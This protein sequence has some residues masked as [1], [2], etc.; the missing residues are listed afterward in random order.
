MYHFYSIII[1]LE[2]VIER[3]W[4]SLWKLSRTQKR[5]KVQKMIK[6]KEVWDLSLL[7]SVSVT[8]LL[9]FCS[10]INI[11]TLVPEALFSKWKQ[12]EIEWVRHRI[13]CHFWGKVYLSWGVAKE[14]FFGGVCPKI[15]GGSGCSIVHL[16]CPAQSFQ[17]C[18]LQACVQC[19]IP[20][21]N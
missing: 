2:K 4:Q 21:P 12:K 14:H 16:P 20:N 9:A 15:M 8:F 7:L 10:T 18:S 13:C 19:D 11:R 6:K 17:Y 3:K 5:K 1:I